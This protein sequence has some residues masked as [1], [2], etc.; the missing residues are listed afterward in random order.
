MVLH[1]KA[2]VFMQ[3]ASDLSIFFKPKF[4]FRSKATWINL[5]PP[6][7]VKFQFSD[8]GSHLIAQLKRT[9]MNI[10]GRYNSFMCKD[11]IYICF[12]NMH[13]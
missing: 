3:T 10:P 11:F 1:E 8:G 6:P 13:V 5:N 9:V 7:A 4:V 2:T 12:E